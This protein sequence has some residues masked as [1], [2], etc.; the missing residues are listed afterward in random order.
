MSPRVTC[1]R[2]QSPLLP[3]RCPPERR[4][5]PAVAGPRLSVTHALLRTQ[6][7]SPRLFGAVSLNF[8]LV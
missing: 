7:R 2:A 1:A 6:T 5:G 4:G 3:A 8:L